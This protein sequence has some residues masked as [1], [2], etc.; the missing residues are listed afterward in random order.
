MFLLSKPSP[1]LQV[2]VQARPQRQPAGTNESVNEDDPE[3][4]EHRIHA[5]EAEQRE[6]R[7]T[8][9][10]VDRVALTGAEETVDDPRLAANFRRHPPGCV[11]D[12]G[13]RKA[14]QDRPQNPARGV[15]FAAPEQHRRYQH[16]QQEP[17]PESRHDVVAVIQQR[18]WTGPLVRR[19]VVQAFH[20]GRSCAIDE[21]AENVVDRHRIVDL[22][23]VLVRLADEDHRRT[24]LRAEEP[25][26][27]GDGGRLILRHVAAV[28]VAGGKDLHDAGDEACDDS[29]FHEQAAEVLI[30]LFE[31]IKRA[32]GGDDERCGNDGSAHVVRVLQPCPRI[33]HE[34][35][36]A[37]D[38]IGAVGEQAVRD[39]VLHPGVGNDDEETGDP[40]ADE[41]HERRAEVSEFREALLAEEEEAEEGRF[42]EES[43]DAFHSKRLADDPARASREL[44]PVGAELEF[45][46]NAGHH[47]E[48]EVDG[49]DFRPEARGLIPA[50]LPGTQSD[51]LHGHHQQRQAHREL[52]E[53]IVERDRESKVNTVQKEGVHTVLT[54]TAEGAVGL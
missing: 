12:I 27:P 47:A 24:L 2:Q 42:E 15:K 18:Q 29:D 38:F 11:G 22:L 13:Q 46:R 44:R 9:R 37:R 49:E 7:V 41:D 19:K 30:A 1:P 45:H 48:Q 6:E 50:L 51:E 23:R 8:G 4:R 54:V 16:E 17:G 53:Q 26:H 25:F 14:E 34:V 39:G 28:E 43:E 21:E 31:Q 20:L 40:G 52:R 32:G 35:P 3:D 33:Q 5:E 36:E 10:D